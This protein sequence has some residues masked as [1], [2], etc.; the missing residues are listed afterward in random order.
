MRALRPLSAEHTK[1]SR[2]AGKHE[3]DGSAFRDGLLDVLIQIGRERQAI[4]DKMREALLAGD[5]GAALAFARELTGLPKKPHL[6]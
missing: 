5:D 6:H 1:K 4:M 3:A 2:P